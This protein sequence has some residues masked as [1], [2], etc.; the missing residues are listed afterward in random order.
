MA[1]ELLRE[2]AVIYLPIC[3]HAKKAIAFTNRGTNAWIGTTFLKGLHRAYLVNF[4]C[5][6]N[7]DPKWKYYGRWDRARSSSFINGLFANAT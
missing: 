2:G 3:W 6:R 4:C 7:W 1:T 5:F